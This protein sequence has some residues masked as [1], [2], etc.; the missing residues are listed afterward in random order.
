MRFAARHKNHV[1]WVRRFASQ[2]CAET[3]TG[4]K[5]CRSWVPRAALRKVCRRVRSA[6]ELAGCK[7]W[8]ASRRLTFCTS[9]EFF[10]RGF[11]FG[12]VCR[13][14]TGPSWPVVTLS[15]GL[16]PWA[17]L[18]AWKSS[19]SHF[20]RVFGSGL[21]CP[22]ESSRKDHLLCLHSCMPTFN[23]L[24]SCVMCALHGGILT[25]ISLAWRTS[26]MGRCVHS[27]RARGG[28]IVGGQWGC[29]RVCGHGQVWSII[30]VTG[31]GLILIVTKPTLHECRNI[32]ISWDRVDCIKS[33][34][35]TQYGWSPNLRCVNETTS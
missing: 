28:S 24:A 17:I 32:I 3:P 4:C 6:A 5:L 29:Y 27:T 7:L 13:R 34:G 35:P 16:R 8:G 12:K 1:E 18:S 33:R 23:L 11:P 19:L 25:N 14:Y 26:R 22:L 2:K 30:T 15:K 9:I 31:P 10:T 21:Y 20:L